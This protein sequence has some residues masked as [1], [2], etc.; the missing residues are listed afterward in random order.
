VRRRHH[1]IVLLRPTDRR[2]STRSGHVSVVPGLLTLR[3]ILFDLDDTLADSS[4]AEERI[5][6]DAAAILVARYPDADARSLRLRYLEALHDWY[7]RLQLGEIAFDDF[8]RSRLAAA[9]EPWGDLDDDTFAAYSAVKL[10]IA[11]EL[12]PASGAIATLRALRRR[13]IRVGILT[14]GPSAFQRRKLATTALDREVDAIGISGELGVA[15]PD[16]EAFRG[17]LALLGTAADETAMIGD[18]LANDVVG[19]VGA[20]LAA[21][22]WLNARREGIPPPGTHVADTVPDA[23][24][25]LGLA[26][27]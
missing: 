18:S 3:G 23:V 1:R 4:A 22:V 11:D 10:R 9:L 6:E 21:A 27:V 20:G 8:R 13:G 16:P 17:A 26:T 19:A 14:N 24:A 15:K 2:S 5:W 25:A 7:P 12:L